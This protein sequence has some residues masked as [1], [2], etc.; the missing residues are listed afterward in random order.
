MM[1]IVDPLHIETIAANAWPAAETAECHGWR[2]RATGGVT[3]RANSVWPNRRSATAPSLDAHLEQVE[4]WYRQRGLPA[5]FQVTPVSQPVNLAAALEARGYRTRPGALV[6]RAPLSL[7]HRRTTGAG[8]QASEQVQADSP[9]VTVESSVTQ[10]WLDLYCTL[11]GYTGHDAAT[12]GAIIRRI[13]QPLGLAAAT[14]GGE[15]AGVVMGV[16]EGEWLGIFGMITSAG[17]RRQGVAR[18][19]LH[20]LAH[21][22]LAAGATHSY[23]QVMTTNQAARALYAGVAFAEVYGYEYWVSG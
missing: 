10:R 19:L 20:H 3:G 7:V 16:I 17:H 21:W 23:L 13:R 8:G 14:V 22:A 6:Q 2:L 18:A 1:S 11:E 15:A 9:L 4:A 5:V 12:R